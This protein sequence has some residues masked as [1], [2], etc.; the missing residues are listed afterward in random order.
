M[1]HSGYS[2]STIDKFMSS[3]EWRGILLSRLIRVGSMVKSLANA[4]VS[5][6]KY[7]HFIHQ[8]MRLTNKKV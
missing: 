4:A 2:V 7:L 5:E 8:E 3:N 6:P 1:E